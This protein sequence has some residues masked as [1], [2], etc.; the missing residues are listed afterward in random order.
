MY[1]VIMSQQSDHQFR[2]LQKIAIKRSRFHVHPLWFTERNKHKR[3]RC[4]WC[5][6][7]SSFRKEF[8][9]TLL[10]NF[11]NVTLFQRLRYVFVDSVHDPGRG[12]VLSR[13][14]DSIMIST[15]RCL[16]WEQ[17]V[18]SRTGPIFVSPQIHLALCCR[19][20]FLSLTSSFV[21]S[22]CSV[23]HFCQT[24]FARSSTSCDFHSEKNGILRFDYWLHKR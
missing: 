24:A 12:R 3:Q 15:P 6:S 17:I 5:L 4:I 13:N 7:W 20:D 16:W 21:I 11:F 9:C 14:K 22:T 19:H 2:Y 1:W 10:Y 8:L 18:T 23:W